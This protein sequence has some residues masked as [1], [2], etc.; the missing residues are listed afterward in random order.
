[1][2]PEVL[3]Q[4]PVEI[5]VALAS[6][7]AAYV[8]AYTG[9]RDRHRPVE[10]V[11]I[12]LVFSL[13]ASFAFWLFAPY[14]PV[15]SYAAGLVGSIACGV[16]WRKLGRPTVAFLLR[17]GD[18]TWTDDAPSALATL[19]ENNKFRVTQV[20]VL[21]D[22]GTWLSCRN[23]AVFENAPFG[24][25]LLGPNGDVAIHLTHEQSPGGEER[26]LATVYDPHY[27]YRITWLPASRIRRITMRH[28]PSRLSRAA[29][30][31]ASVPSRLERSASSA[32]K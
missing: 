10:I 27:G 24:A 5:Q 13:V 32:G 17:Q 25:F 9:L 4:L 14:G 22:D 2:N 16:I 6:G 15:I 31:A 1:M 30:A 11:F 8:V 21:L 29:E 12:S 18:V 28:K 20:A 3:K 19:S 7:Y 26:E 23:A